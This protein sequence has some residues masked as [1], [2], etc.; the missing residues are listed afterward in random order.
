MHKNYML[1][2]LQIFLAKGNVPAKNYNYF[3]DILLDT[4]RDEIATCLERSYRKISTQDATRMLNLVGSSA[5][6]DYG[7]KVTMSN[8]NIFSCMPYSTLF[9]DSECYY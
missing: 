6:K 1:F 7:N 3:I 2:S 4:V 5:I 9:C 8:V